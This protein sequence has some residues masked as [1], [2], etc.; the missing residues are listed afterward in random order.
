MQNLKVLQK[1]GKV[2]LIAQVVWK[3]IYWKVFP[4]EIMTK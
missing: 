4:I 3:T 1:K 2:L